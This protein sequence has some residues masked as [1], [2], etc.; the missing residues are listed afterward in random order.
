MWLLSALL[1]NGDMSDGTISIARQIQQDRE[2]GA[3]RLVAEYKERLYAAAFSLCG[4]A[5]EAE[6]L[7]FRT[8]EQVL[9]KIESYREDQ[10][11]YSWTYTILL[12]YYRMSLRRSDRRNTVPVGDA[13]EMEAVVAAA[14]GAFAGADVAAQGHPAT[15]AIDG[16]TLRI[17]IS[18]LP[19]DKREVLILHYFMDQSVSKIA[20]MLSIAD[21]T[22]MSRLHYARIALR[23]RLGVSMKKPAVLL[24]AVV[25][26]LAASAAVVV[27]VVNGTGAKDADT[28]PLLQESR[29]DADEDISTKG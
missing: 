14:P 20:K 11:F 25:L 3:A 19:P 27:S 2:K 24:A 12:N 21:G 23:Q 22:V 9:D 8:F 6:D 1:Y 4:D 18:H 10:A 26:F 13:T 29:P 17:A 28:N 5:T 7:V 15:S 16:D